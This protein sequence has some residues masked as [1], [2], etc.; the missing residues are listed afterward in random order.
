MKPHRV[1]MH[2]LGALVSV[3][4]GALELV[5]VPDSVPVLR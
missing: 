3:C 4:T 1:I 2:I 5:L